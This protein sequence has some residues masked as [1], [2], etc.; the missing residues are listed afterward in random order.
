MAMAG[1]KKG[2]AE[3]GGKPKKDKKKLIIIVVA[4]AAAWKF[5]L[6][7][8]GGSNGAEGAT[9]TTQMHPGDA[10]AVGDPIVVNLADSDRDR[11]AR[12]G[13]AIVLPGHG[14]SSE[15]EATGEETTTRRR[16]SSAT[17]DTSAGTESN[18]AGETATSTA[19]T[20]ASTETTADG[21][22]LGAAAP[23]RP[24]LAAM[25]RSGGSGDPAAELE[26]RF[27]RLR[28][29]AISIIRTYSAAEL[30]SDEGPSNLEAD[31][32]DA[33]YEIYGHD[34]IYGVIITELIVQ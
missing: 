21:H 10:V 26:P 34:D 17:G 14:E 6:L 19:T 25:P 12:V 11:Y 23:N 29:A 5:G 16:S 8:I 27:P 24:A 31:I 32:S 33:A 3:E 22:A 2:D 1:K 18:G 7:P 15:T 13:I 9:A 4:L 30:L 28:A 20:A